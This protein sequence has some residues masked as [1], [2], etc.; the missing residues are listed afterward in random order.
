MSINEP[1]KKILTWPQTMFELTFQKEREQP[2]L[3][4]AKQQEEDDE[5]IPQQSQQRPLQY[6]AIFLSDNR[7]IALEIS[8]TNK[9]KPL[10]P[11]PKQGVALFDPYRF[12]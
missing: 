6:F 2:N 11:K 12:L 5:L 1:T 8:M 9:L 10:N 4:D 3:K 7:T